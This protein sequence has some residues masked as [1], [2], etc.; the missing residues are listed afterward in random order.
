[1]KLKSDE[2]QEL[3]FS[4]KNYIFPQKIEKVSATWDSASMILKTPYLIKLRY[5]KKMSNFD[6]SSN[7]AKP[8]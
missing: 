8:I 6:L 5:K 7:K 3:L 2:I 1:M 4:L